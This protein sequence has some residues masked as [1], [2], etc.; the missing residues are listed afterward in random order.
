MYSV[1]MVKFVVKNVREEVQF[2]GI[3]AQKTSVKQRQ[4][5]FLKAFELIC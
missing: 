3:S 2:E 5:S 1:K 4:V